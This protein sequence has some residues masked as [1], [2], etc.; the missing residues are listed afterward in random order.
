MRGR[1]GDSQPRFHRAGCPIARK[2]L[3]NTRWSGV[4]DQRAYRWNSVF[5]GKGLGERDGR[6]HCDMKGMI[7]EL[8]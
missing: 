6:G 1:S 4:G 3:V 5:V 7:D 8:Q 2:V